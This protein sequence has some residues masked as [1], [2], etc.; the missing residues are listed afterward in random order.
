MLHRLPPSGDGGS[1][2]RPVGAHPWA[3]GAGLSRGWLGDGGAGSS[4]SS[5]S[6]SGRPAHQPRTPQSLGGKPLSRRRCGRLFAAAGWW[7]EREGRG[8]HERPHHWFSSGLLRGA[9]VPRLTHRP[10]LIPPSPGLSETPK[11]MPPRDTL[12]GS[13]GCLQFK[14]CMTQWVMEWP[15]F[16]V[17]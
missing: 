6:I 17:H 14:W 9:S 13:T 10:P 1:E 3:K 5:L 11:I 16:Q 4:S 12:Q 7:G 2:T 8:L 15:G